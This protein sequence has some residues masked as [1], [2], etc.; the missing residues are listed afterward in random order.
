MA[1]RVAIE[2]RDEP[3]EQGDETTQ[4]PEPNATDETALGSFLLL[5][6]GARLPE[7]LNQGENERTE[8]DAAEGVGGGATEGA[9]RGTVGHALRRVGEEVPGA[10]DAGDGGVYGVLEP[11]AEPVHGKGDVDD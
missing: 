8:A 1:E 4:D 9:A 6:D 7:H 11:F 2:E 3:I 5:R 10:V